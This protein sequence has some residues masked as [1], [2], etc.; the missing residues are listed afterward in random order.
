MKLNPYLKKIRLSVVLALVLSST[1]SPKS[2]SASPTT[3]PRTS[4]ATCRIEVDDA[5]ISTSILKNR[6]IRAVKVNAKSIC[7][8]RQERVTLTL[9]IYKVGKFSNY[10]MHRTQTNPDSPKSSGLI[11]RIQ[12]SKVLCINSK[13]SSYFG[14]VF[15]KAFIQGKWQ[16]AG[17]TR[18][19]NITKL[20]CGT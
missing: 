16:I 19:T 13:S 5:H 8:V 4:K 14:I 9:E 6:G 18:S 3:L 12:D 1:L 20:N 11:I 7:N 2:N 15:S 10:L 17:N